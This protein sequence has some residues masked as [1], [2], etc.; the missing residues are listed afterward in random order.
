[1]K[2][3]ATSDDPMAMP[4]NSDFSL[5]SYNACN[6][7][8]PCTTN[9]RFEALRARVRQREADNAALRLQTFSGSDHVVDERGS[10]SFVV[11]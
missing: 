5:D 2:R 1:M 10:S 9:A 3:K 11:D 7:K 6:G 8:V 4:T